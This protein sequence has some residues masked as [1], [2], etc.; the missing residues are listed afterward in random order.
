MDSSRLLARLSDTLRH[1]IAPA[2]GEE[3]PRTQAFMASVILERV[4][5]ELALESAHREAE[6]RDVAE[7]IATLGLVLAS[8]P[9]AVGSALAE[10]EAAGTVDAIGPLVQSLHSWGGD[11][12]S[13]VA[14]L[15]EIRPVLRRDIDRRMEI[16]R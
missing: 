2:V 16:A 14:A 4:S 10:V 13:V 6:R 12:P 5:R 1:E 15:A 9:A 8:T 7:L 11:E 3:Y